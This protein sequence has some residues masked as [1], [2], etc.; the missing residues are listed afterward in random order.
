[1]KIAQTLRDANGSWT[2]LNGPADIMPQL[3][4]YFGAPEI[5]AGGAPSRELRRMFDGAHIIGCSTGGEIV[6]REVTDNS[7]IA[8]AL[9]FAATP[10]RT[11]AVH[12]QAFAD[13]AEA[14]AAL[15]AQLPLKD[16][17]HVFVLSDG[18]M[19]NGSALIHGLRRVLPPAVGLSGG[20][21]GDG[22]RFEKTF[23]DADRLPEQGVIAAVGFYG[24]HIVA[25]TGSV[26][27]WEPFGPERVI[28]RAN[29]NV[30]FE[31][32]GRPALQL[33]RDYL[34]EEAER[35]PS[36]ALLF[37]LTVRPAADK[38]AAVVRTIVG[39]NEAEQ[40]MIFAGDIQQGHI[41]R[42]MRG[43]HLELAEGAAAAATAANAKSPTFALLVSCI[44]RKLLLGQ[45]VAEEVEAVG[46]VFGPNVTLSG[47]YSYGEI[48][49]H[50]F[51]G[52]CQL[53]NQTMTVTSFSE[54]A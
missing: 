11:A 36:S 19:V 42:L 12:V 41:G 39:I 29:E 8:T 15:A 32:D 33:Y 40:S 6:G 9:E 46:D 43:G 52:D 13:A 10:I 28:T 7:V 1:M 38:D 37:P 49:P 4:L 22:S 45:R 23:V 2:R 26:G 50:H 27:G 54:R 25:N 17:R 14:G 20:L 51:T 18:T 21:A 35:L 3:V 47:F 30:L 48:A 24:D 16:L 5:M 44:G 34:G 31:L 53:H